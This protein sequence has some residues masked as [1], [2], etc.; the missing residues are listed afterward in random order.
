M[1]EEMNTVECLEC[2]K[3]F[4]EIVD[5]PIDICPHCGNTDKQKTI[6][7]VETD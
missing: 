4:V 7:L 2:S 3:T 6:Y 1:S 5:Q